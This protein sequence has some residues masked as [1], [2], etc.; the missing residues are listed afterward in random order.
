MRNS[1]ELTAD[2]DEKQARWLATIPIARAG[3]TLFHDTY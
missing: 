1:R 2:H 3:L